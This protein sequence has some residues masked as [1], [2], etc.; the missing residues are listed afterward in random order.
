MSIT[1][2]LPANESQ[3]SASSTLITISGSGACTG[4]VL[5]DFDTGDL[6][7]G[8]L[9]IGDFAMGDRGERLIE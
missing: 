9:D 2:A 3:I 8:D 7:A 6:F 5:D 1:F 4:V